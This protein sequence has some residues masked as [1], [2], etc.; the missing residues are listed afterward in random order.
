MPALRIAVVAC[1]A[2]FAAPTAG[3]DDK[4]DSKKGDQKPTWTGTIKVEGKKSKFALAEM[5]KVAMPD[6][7]RTALTA[8]KAGDAD[9]KVVDVELD[10]ED[11]YLVWEVEVAVRNQDGITK[12]IVDAGSG[13]VLASEV[14]KEEENK[15][16]EEGKDKKGE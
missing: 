15:K 4:K 10:A 6:A 1:L 9:K 16:K 11:G 8:V 2:A 5:A 12:V 14:E 7:V 3:A 13:K